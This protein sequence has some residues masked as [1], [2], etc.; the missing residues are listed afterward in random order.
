MTLFDVRRD[1][2]QPVN[3]ERHRERD[4][5]VGGREGKM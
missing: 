3:H 2:S 5:N 4:H 1:S